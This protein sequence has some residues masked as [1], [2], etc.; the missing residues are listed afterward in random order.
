[1]VKTLKFFNVQFAICVAI[2]I[3]LIGCAAPEKRPSPLPGHPKPYKVG[4]RWYQP[5][6]HARGFQERGI[7]SWYGK[8]FHGRKTSSGEIYNMYAKTAAHK[9]LPLGTYVRVYNLRNGKTVDVRINDRGPFVRGRIIDLSYAAAQQIGLVGPGTAPVKIVALGSVKKTVVGGKVQSTL[10]PGN[11]YVGDFTIQVG[12][13]KDKENAIRLRN[14]LA[15]T[16]KNA[17]I[18]VYESPKGIFYRVRVARCKTLDKAREYEKRLEA[19]GYPDAI[20]V[21]R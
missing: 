19:D 8:P 5:R 10:V 11:Y 20:V 6:K 12:A 3:F 2:S 13:F 21:A 9:T 7:A 4:K 14:K 17:H 16:Y 18:M 1:M 15:Q